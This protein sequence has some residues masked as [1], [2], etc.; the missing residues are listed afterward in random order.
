MDR[1]TSSPGDRTAASS[2]S[3]ADTSRGAPGTIVTST[4]SATMAAGYRRI[5]NS[6]AC[7]VLA[8]LPKGS[9]TVNVS[10]Y[11]TSLVWAYVQGA[12]D[13]ETV[14]GRLLRH[15]DLQ[16]RRRFR[17][18]CLP[19]LN[20]HRRA[21][22]FVSYPPYADVQ[23]G[24]TVHGGNLTI[25]QYSG[26]RGFGAGKVSWKADGSA[27]AYAMRPGS[28]IRQIPANPSYGAIG[29]DLPVVEKA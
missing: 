8:G 6:P 12:P 20:R 15:G 17:A 11:T 2:L 28:A 19:G 7:A 29:V 14:L 5:T 10:N 22:R 1:R 13:V 27:L 25:M 26:F 16:R 23:P 24:Q 18:G 21:D 9:V 4:S 3:P